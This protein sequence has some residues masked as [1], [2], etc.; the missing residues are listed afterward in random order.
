MIASPLA[1]H[2]AESFL[3]NSCFDKF[4]QLE[5]FSPQANQIQDIWRHFFPRFLQF[6][7]LDKISPRVLI[8]L[9]ALQKI[10]QNTSDLHSQIV[11]WSVALILKCQ[12]KL[13]SKGKKISFFYVL[14]R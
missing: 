3:L 9:H 2:L 13:Y 4:G 11:V 1:H 7:S 10:P 12:T 14:T 6:T 5:K 8:G